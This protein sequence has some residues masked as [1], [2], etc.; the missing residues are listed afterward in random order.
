MQAKFYT[1]T[2]YMSMILERKLKFFQLAFPNNDLTVVH[3]HPQKAEILQI[4]S[5]VYSDRLKLRLHPL[6]R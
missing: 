2:T 6:I 4:Q 1:N 3:D 5:L